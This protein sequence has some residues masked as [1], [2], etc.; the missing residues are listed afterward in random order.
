MTQTKRIILNV[1]ATYGR[2]FI[3]L[4]MGLFSARWV[5]EALGQ[6]DFGLYG[7][8]GSVI[9]FVTFLN[10][11][12]SMS[13]TRFYS[14]SIGA[15]KNM[16]AS[17]ANDDLKGWFNTALSIH[18]CLP[19]I[20]IAIGYPVCAYALEHWLMIP[21]ERMQSCVWVLR[22]SFACAFVSMISAPYVAMFTAYQYITELVVFNL[23]QTTV[24]FGGA[25]ALLHCPGDR[26]IAYAALHL[27]VYCSILIL[28]VF[29]ARK[30]FP[31]CRIS[32]SQ[33]FDTKRLKEVFVFSGMKAIGGLAWVLRGNG[34]SMLLNIAFGP[35]AN[36]AFSVSQQL[37]SQASAF[38]GHLIGA[39]TPAVTAA[40]GARETDNARSMTMR[41]CKFGA[42]LVIFFGIP[43]MAEMEYFLTLW[44]K[45]VPLYAKELCMA[46][47]L[48]FLLDYL[49]NG[50]QI[51]ISAYG[52]ITAWQTYDAIVLF[53]T[54]PIG[55][56]YIKLGFGIPGIGYAYLT[57]IGL[58]SLGRLYFAKKLMNISI[59]EWSKTVFTPLTFLVLVVYT[60][61]T[62]IVRN[63][64]MSFLRLFVT[65]LSSF[66]TTFVFTWL[67]VLDKQ[68]RSYVLTGIN[69]L[70]YKLFRKR[71]I[72]TSI[73]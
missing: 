12:L 38:S 23:L 52:K 39:M 21:L 70:K 29:R 46:M 5:L 62:L 33:M 36:A 20:L 61:T 51:A 60:S 48:V 13:M 42:L 16:T 55:W 19:L 31:A 68:E 22:M 2:S 71:Q 72:V 40:V 3:T 57:T 34:S 26:L 11:V 41:C 1:A 15:G 44:L 25:Y 17:E 4:F 9:F 24:L 54:L 64:E 59:L 73:N 32:L 7:V 58:M 8:V 35:K 18:I 28:Q 63:M 14:F 53:C 37:S 27:V 43:L 49:T 65:S 67:I 66:I 56:G 45:I 47:I 10:T 30:I 69:K 6:T 50:H